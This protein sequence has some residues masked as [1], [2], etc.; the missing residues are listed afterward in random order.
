MQVFIDTCTHTDARMPEHM[1]RATCMGR[2]FGSHWTNVLSRLFSL[3][4]QNCLQVSA[5]C[6]S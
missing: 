1:N 6:E 2:L 3:R 4:L 5:P